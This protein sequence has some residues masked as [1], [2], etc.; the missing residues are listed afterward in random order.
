MKEMLVDL[1]RHRDDQG[2]R[3]VWLQVVTPQLEAMGIVLV[4]HFKSLLPLLFHWLHARDETTQILVSATFL[5]CQSMSEWNEMT[6]SRHWHMMYVQ[7]SA[8]FC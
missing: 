1:G 6:C 5:L 2:R 4:A 8:W 3:I 7:E